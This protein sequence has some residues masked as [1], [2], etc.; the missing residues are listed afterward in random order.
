LLFSAPEPTLIFSNKFD[1]RQISP[2]SKNYKLISDTR[3]SSAVALD[4]KDE[5]VYYTDLLNKTISRVHRN[6][7]NKPKVVVKGLEKPESMAIDWNHGKLYWIDTGKNTLSVANLDG[8]HVKTIIR[9][10]D[11]VQLRTLAIYPEKG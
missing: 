3:S 6:E 9:G 2:H 8:S 10:S 7:T 1:V 4:V 11:N 5:M